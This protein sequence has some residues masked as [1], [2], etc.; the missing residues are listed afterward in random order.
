[1]ELNRP[2]NVPAAGW[3][4]TDGF[5]GGDS[6]EAVKAWHVLILRL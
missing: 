1:M 4:D 3:L 6:R 5:E 2:F